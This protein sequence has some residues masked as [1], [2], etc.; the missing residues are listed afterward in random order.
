MLV[1]PEQRQGLPPIDTIRTIGDIE[2]Y[3]YMKGK[4]VDII[5]TILN[6][7]A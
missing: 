4:S 2:G 1:P 5:D 3:N 6:R 7:K